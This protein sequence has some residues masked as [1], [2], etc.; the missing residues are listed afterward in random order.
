MDSQNQSWKIW[1]FVFCLNIFAI[2][3]AFYLKSVGID[4]YALRGSS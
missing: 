1:I 2:G 4:V 3:G